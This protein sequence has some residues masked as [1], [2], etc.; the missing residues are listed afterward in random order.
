[1]ALSVYTG[2]VYII[3]FKKTKCTK[4]NLIQHYFSIYSFNCTCRKFDKELNMM[5]LLYFLF[6][7]FIDLTVD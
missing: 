5:L 7:T 1:M 2:E 3:M 4:I 6:L